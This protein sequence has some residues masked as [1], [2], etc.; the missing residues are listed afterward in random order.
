MASAAGEIQVRTTPKRPVKRRR[1]RA[2]P[3]NAMRGRPQ[4]P[5]QADNDRHAV[6]LLQMMLC[7]SIDGSLPSVRV[8]A[9]RAACS[10]EGDLQE[11]RNVSG[12]AKPLLAGTGRRNSPV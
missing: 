5:L 2:A 9:M 1:Y 10:K 6:A 3:A 11:V 4:I 12:A 7:T 8:A